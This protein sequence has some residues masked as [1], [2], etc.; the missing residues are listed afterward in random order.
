MLVF[1]LFLAFLAA[2]V[3]GALVIFAAGM[4]DTPSDASP[5]YALVLFCA[6]GFGAAVTL[7]IL[8]ARFAHWVLS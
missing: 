8:L 6:G 1:L 2:F 4:A 3:W 5:I 7:L